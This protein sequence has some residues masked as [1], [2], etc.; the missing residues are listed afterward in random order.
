[1]QPKIEILDKRIQENYPSLPLAYSNYFEVPLNRED[2]GKRR[3][4]H[5]AICNQQLFAHLEALSKEGIELSEEVSNA[6]LMEAIKRNPQK[7]P[8]EELTWHHCHS[9]NVINNTKGVM[10]LVSRKQ[11]EDKRFSEL[12]HLS[13]KAA[14][15]NG[16]FRRELHGISLKVILLMYL[17]RKFKHCLTTAWR[18]LY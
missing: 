7:N 12:F 16:L 10:H 17:K 5:N 2:F 18:L 4:K 11:H 14:I 6:T 1:M 9:Q 8:H 15:M 3:Q 13:K